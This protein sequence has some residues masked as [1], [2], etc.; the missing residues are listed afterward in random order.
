MRRV[1]LGDIQTAQEAMMKAARE[2]V[3]MVKLINHLAYDD[4]IQD[5]IELFR[6]TARALLAKLDR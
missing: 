5:N 2:R 1:T 4:D 6:Q 3:E